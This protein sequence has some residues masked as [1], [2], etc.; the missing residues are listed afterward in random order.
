MAGQ[1]Q[2]Y[3]ALLRLSDLTDDGDTNKGTKP[4][5]TDS[6]TGDLKV[7]TLTLAA[8]GSAIAVGNTGLTTVPTIG[9]VATFGNLWGGSAKFVQTGDPSASDGADGDFWFKYEA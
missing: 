1:A 6:S 5:T 7:T 2:T 8:V 3:S 9:Q 4:L